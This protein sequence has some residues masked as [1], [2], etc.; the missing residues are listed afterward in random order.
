MTDSENPPLVPQ[1]GSDANK[2]ID[3]E[4]NYDTHKGIIAWFARNSVAA[5]LL[6]VGII[7]LGLTSAFTIR[8][9]MFPQIEN[10]WLNV[11]IYYPGAD[12]QE[13]AE[14]ITVKLEEA[15]S[16]VTGV[17]RIITNSNR[18]SAQAY[19]KV[20][21]SYDPQEVLD[22][23]KSSV[24]SISSF[25]DGMERPRIKRF[26][27]RQEVMYVSLAGDMEM[28]KLKAFGETIHDEIRGL[29]G[30]NIAEYYSGADYEIGIEVSKDKLREYKLNFAEIATAVRN[31]STNRS[32]GV[33]RAE[34]GFI[35]LRVEEQAYIGA[36]F[37]EIPVRILPDGTQLYLRDVAEV[38]DGFVEGINYSKLNG[39]NTV[40]F[41]IGA[42]EDQSITDVAE[43]VSA[44]LEEKQSELPQGVTLEPWVDLTYYLKGRLNMMLKNMFF[45]GVL[46]FLM[47]TLFLRMRLAFWV[48]MGLPVSFFGALM[49]LPLGF[50]DVTINV[51]SLFAFIMVLGVVVDDAIV[52]GE[53]IYTEVEEKG[54]TMDNVIRGAHRVAMPATFGVLTTVAAFAPM[55]FESGPNSAF[56]H[57]IGFVVVFCLLFSL[58]ESKLILPAHLAKMKP[59]DPNKSGLLNNIRGAVDRNLRYF[60]QNIYTPFLAKALHF[61]YTAL[62][63]FISVSVIT[64]GLFVG[65]IIKFQGMP[66][67][68]HDFSRIEFEMNPNTPEQVTLDALLAIERMIQNV[69][70]QLEKEF[71]TKLVDNLYTDLESRTSG[72]VQAKLID[73]ELRPIDTFELSKRWREAMPEISGLKQLTIVDNVFS[74][75]RNDGD[76]TFRIDS[77]N[78]QQLRM[79]A[80][81]IKKGLSEIDG[82]YDVNDSEAQFATEAKFKLK[83][84]AYSMGLTTR[85]VASQAGFSLYGIEAQRIVRDRDE[86]RVMVRYPVEERNT[87][88]LID[89]VLIHTPAGNDVP[90]SEIANIEFADGVNQ[91]YREDGNRAVTIWA[92]LDAEKA[93]ALEVAETMKK[94]VFENV[95][96][97][98]PEVNI[99]EAGKL[100]HE[101]EDAADFWR[102]LLLIVLM[103]YILLAL[104]LRSY[105]QPIV[106]MLVIP[107]GV[108]GAILGHFIL[109]MD[110]SQL[111]LFG[112][113]AAIG[114]VVN[115]SLVFVDH[116]NKSRKMGVG[117]LEAV[118][119]AGQRRFRAIVLTSLT[120][121]IGLMPIILETSLQAKIVIPMAVSLAF[122]VLFATVVT[123][124]L[125]PSLYVIGVDIKRLFTRLFRWILVVFDRNS[126]SPSSR[127][128]L[129]GNS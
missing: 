108:T 8:K 4:E 72:E 106:V 11:A 114:V 120:T 53:S 88:V 103:I 94:S 54:Q 73:P 104:A 16:S 14:S 47:L 3:P 101:R 36:Q 18:G 51:A 111:S 48:M 42:S 82:V 75:G 93:K 67:V 27:Y 9:Q 91:I 5:N 22:E 28:R 35:S 55:V 109:G 65:G 32:A 49:L 46:V 12:P 98:Y 97:K 52:I 38:K 44:Y 31:F 83:P 90:L 115:D 77:Q 117:L 21:D 58:V 20:L 57:A 92:S 13:I 29:P 112:I 15:I 113:F 30:I 39:Q 84:L 127:K 107:F 1:K 23:V 61:R 64:A 60:I 56:P 123:L 74:G 118:I 37:E 125:V 34:D 43:I 17:E 78:E 79:A 102:N 24:D 85:E 68:P 70:Q 80:N 121:F 96:S 66:K 87:A 124:L 122:G 7:L 89:D 119:F 59:L 25:P 62:A 63:S 40:T 33:I 95:E 19:I 128:S 26:R 81:E 50:V 129:S 6:M 76:V 105:G 10:T 99:E 110:I 71:G 69:D 45:G 100:K 126:A 2:S 116:V 86:I 41:F